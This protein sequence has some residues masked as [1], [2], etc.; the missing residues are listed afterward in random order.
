MFGYIHELGLIV[1]SI[2]SAL[3]LLL[4]VAK[5]LGEEFEATA[6]VWIRTF[7]RIQ[8]EWRKPVNVEEESFQPPQPLDQTDSKRELDSGG[9]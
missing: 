6:L 8:E 9:P 3:S 4:V 1:F 7:K 5:P 2:A